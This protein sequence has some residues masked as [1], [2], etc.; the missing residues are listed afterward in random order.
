M[1]F[2][3]PFGVSAV[4]VAVI[5]PAKSNCCPPLKPCTL[6]VE[7]KVSRAAFLGCR[8]ARFRCSVPAT[9]LPGYDYLTI[10]CETLNQTKV[11]DKVTIATESGDSLAVSILGNDRSGLL[12]ELLATFRQFG[13]AV[14]KASV[15][16]SGTEVNDTF[17]LSYSDTDQSSDEADL[18]ANLHHALMDVLSG[19]GF[20]SLRAKARK[21][22]GGNKVITEQVGA[23]RLSIVDQ[24]M[25]SAI[26]VRCP[27]RDFLLHDIVGLLKYMELNVVAAHIETSGS[28]ISDQFIVSWHGSKLSEDMKSEVRNSLMTLLS[29]RET[30]A[31]DNDSY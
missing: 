26:N 7:K 2:V 16:T 12:E 10:R 15:S 28:Q 1:A 29:N 22:V 25:T 14:V 27:D 8:T 31:A 11:Q 24:D 21:S 30:M 9:R 20:G 13:L 17:F 4:Q 23:V 3:A 19:K 5:S 6:H 18:V